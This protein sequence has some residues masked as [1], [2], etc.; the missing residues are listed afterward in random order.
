MVS[1]RLFARPAQ[2][3]KRF[4][5]AL[6]VYLWFYGVTALILGYV[7]LKLQWPQGLHDVAWALPPLALLGALVFLPPSSSQPAAGSERG[8][9]MA[10]IIDN[11]CPI[12]FI[13]SIVI[14]GV[15]IAPRHRFIG[16][17]CIAASVVFYGLRSAFLQDKYVQAQHEVSKSSVAL[18]R[19]VDQLRE[20]SIRDGL[21]GVHN[22]RHFDQ[23]LIVEWKRSLRSQL[24]LSLLLIDVDSF[25]DLND[26]CGH[27]EGDE[28]LK[29]IAQQ[30]AAQ[31]KRPG[32]LI[33]RYGG[34]E[35]SV[36]LPSTPQEGALEIAEEMRTAVAALNISN[37]SSGESEVVTIS[38]GVCSRIASSD[39]SL[40]KFLNT[41]DT[42]LYRAKRKGKN[43]VEPA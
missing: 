28:C 18:L 15:R 6:A 4:Y 13:L 42:A 43:R 9:S 22:R 35:F 25:K 23:E 27:L 12:L 38:I 7:E 24:P 17:L 36:I 19:A 33:A 10:L 34:E 8:R 2:G 21:T 20:Q 32:D 41:A 11:F 14:M 26:R 37:P 30:L 1:V 29:K 16:F 3:R 40:E 39:L 31:L 5:D